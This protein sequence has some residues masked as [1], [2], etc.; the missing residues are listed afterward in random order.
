MVM[1]PAG[2]RT[3]GQTLKMS[4]CSIGCAVMIGLL[5]VSCYAHPAEAQAQ[6]ESAMR[7]QAIRVGMTKEVVIDTLGEPDEI[8]PLTE[9]GLLDGDRVLSCW[10]RND[11]EV[12]RWAYGV[13]S[14]G[15][16]ARLGCVSFNRSGRVICA[17]S[18]VQGS[19]QNWVQNPFLPQSF[20][21]NRLV[22]VISDQVVV[23]ERVPAARRS[24]VAGKVGSSIVA[25]AEAE[26]QWLACQIVSVRD[27][28]EGGQLQSFEATVTVTNA[29]SADY[30]CPA[31][32]EDL[33]SLAIL[34]LLD[35]QGRLL[36]R[37]DGRVCGHRGYGFMVVLPANAI[38]R[39]FIPFMPGLHFGRLPEGL[40]HVRISLAD[41]A[42][43]LVTSNEV[44][45]HVR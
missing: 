40:Y 34:E 35:E 21:S 2:Q 5:R 17:W 14:K 28:S 24:P 36:Y 13:A 11:P 27:T 44:A 45:F 43:P 20:F 41:H 16:F 23:S 26:R 7:F 15:A 39:G 9:R 18:P 25:S 29:S 22:T 31:N 42:G 4:R 1:A 32:G 8:R 30:I 37:K 10:E 12:E 6:D 19:D 3:I 38:V 33:K